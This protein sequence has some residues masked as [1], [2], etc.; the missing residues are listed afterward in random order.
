[1]KKLLE[2]E[3]AKKRREAEE[4]KN[5]EKILEVRVCYLLWG[6]KF[7]DKYL[8]KIQCKPI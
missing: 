4:A 2:E 7:K 1:M 3:E 8:Q 6:V 5:A